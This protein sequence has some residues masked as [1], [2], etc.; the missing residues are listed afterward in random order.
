MRSKGKEVLGVGN[1]DHVTWRSFPK[2][3]REHES[4]DAGHAEMRI[5]SPLDHAQKI[6]QAQFLGKEYRRKKMCHQL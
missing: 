4:C 1:P 2:A 5:N 6:Q 3:I